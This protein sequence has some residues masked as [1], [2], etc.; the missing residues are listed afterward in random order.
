MGTFEVGLSAVL[1]SDVAKCLWDP[2]SE[3]QFEQEQAHGSEYLG[4]QEQCYLTG[5]RSGLVGTVT[6]V[7]FGISDAQ[8]KPN[9]SLLLPPADPCVE[10]SATSLAPHLLMCQYASGHDDNGLSL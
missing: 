4:I 7:G 3:M 1:H 2:G 10:L 9:A 8:V 5:I 6:E